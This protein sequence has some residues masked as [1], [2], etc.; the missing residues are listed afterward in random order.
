MESKSKYKSQTLI[1][2]AIGAVSKLAGLYFGFNML[3]GHEQAI[4][5]GIVS[6]ANSS[7]IIGASISVGTSLVTDIFAA[8]G[9]LK[10][11]T[12]LK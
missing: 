10:A 9:R 5:S 7:D 6:V 11:N 2:I 8:K 1:A 12:I 4:A 3:E